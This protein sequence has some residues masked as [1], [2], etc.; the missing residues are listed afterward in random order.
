MGGFPEDDNIHV[1]RL[2]KLW[3]A[4]DLLKRHNGCKS[5][6]EEAEEYL[7]DLVKRS[8]VLVTSRKSNGKI[9]SCRLHDLVREM[10]IRKA[11]EE[12]FLLTDGYVRP[13]M[14]KEGRRISIGH[15]RLQKIWGPTIHTILCFKTILNYSSLAFLLNFRLL[16]V[17]DDIHDNSELLP[18]Q[19]FELFHLRYLA[20]G[21]P[22][23]IPA[24]ISKLENLE[25]L[26][27]RP[28]RR[29]GTYGSLASYLPRE[30]WSMPRLRHLVLTE[31]CMLR[32]PPVRPTLPLENLQTLSGIASFLCSKRILELIPNLKKLGIIYSTNEEHHDLHSLVNLHQL[33][34]LKITASD[35]DHRFSLHGLY[36]AFPLT[37]KKLTLDGGELPWKDMSVV[38]SLPNLQVLKLK[39]YACSGSTWETT[40]GEFPELEFLLIEYSNLEHWIA[41]SDPFPRL[42][43]LLLGHCRY[44]TEIPDSIGDVSTL[45]VIQ[46]DDLN[47]SLLKSVKHIQ[48]VQQGYGNDAFQVRCICSN[49]MLGESK[50]EDNLLL[51]ERR[52]IN[53]VLCFL[54]YL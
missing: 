4:E 33:E 30:I 2:I 27:I 11:Q 21:R 9:K 45:E 41:E 44:L 54:V 1:S 34:K 18:P 3:L 39:N 53:K 6:E 13:E 29:S 12:N 10:C 17:L 50:V 19:I 24:A 23:R 38:G 35:S 36:L 32:D 28:F 20:L 31:Y 37:L 52:D 14:T 22:N 15:S 8:L 49:Q 25:T 7:E 16:R 51:C 5:L 47:G 43:R 42:K 48:E 46:V 26:I 40:D